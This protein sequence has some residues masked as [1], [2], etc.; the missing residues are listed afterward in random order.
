M[1]KKYEETD[2]FWARKMYTL[3]D[4]QIVIYGKYK[5]IKRADSDDIHIELD[6]IMIKYILLT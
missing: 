1:I 5:T 6:E 2:A 4:Q 3:L